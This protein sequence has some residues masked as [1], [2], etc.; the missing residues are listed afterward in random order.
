MQ[1]VYKQ[2]S[3][4]VQTNLLKIWHFVK[5]SSVSS[6]HTPEE[7]IQIHLKGDPS[8]AAPFRKGREGKDTIKLDDLKKVHQQA[9]YTNTILNTIAQQFI[10]G[11]FYVHLMS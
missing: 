3:L 11:L 10:W 9:N 2:P 5:G 7:D 8:M 6:I 4:N 1:E